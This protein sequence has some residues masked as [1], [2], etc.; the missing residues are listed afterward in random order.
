MNWILI[1]LAM[2]IASLTVRTPSNGDREQSGT[3]REAGGS[4]PAVLA[5]AVESGPSAS[6]LNFCPAETSSQTFF[7]F[8][9]PSKIL[10]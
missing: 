4:V 1:K 9:I 8:Y 7:F 10:P 2:L 6:R 5:T 3:E